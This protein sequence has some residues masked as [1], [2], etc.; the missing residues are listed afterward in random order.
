VPYSLNVMMSPTWAFMKNG[1]VRL[2]EGYLN[3][4]PFISSEGLL[5]PTVKIDSIPLD[6]GKLAGF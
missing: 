1:Q 4:E 6:S 3:V 2:V 5:P